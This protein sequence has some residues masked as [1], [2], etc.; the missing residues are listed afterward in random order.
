MYTL[1]ESFFFLLFFT[2]LQTLKW[3][4][5]LPRQEH[6]DQLK[7]QLLPCTSKPLHSQ[8]FHDNFKHHLAA[9]TTL[10]NPVQKEEYREAIVGSL[11]LLLRW[12]TL[13]FFDTNTTVNLECLEF[14]HV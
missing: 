7:E 8:L 2:L 9:L 1:E 3:N 5:P 12:I 11:D 6:V 10:T 14:L 4:F 13:R